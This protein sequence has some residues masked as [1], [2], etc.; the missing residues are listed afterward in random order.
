MDQV[1]KG[2]IPRHKKVLAELKREFSRVRPGTN[3]AKLR[4][5]P[6]LEHATFL[7]R[8]LRSPKFSRE[9]SRL[10]KGVAMFHSDLVYLRANIKALK[11]ILAAEKRGPSS[12]KKTKRPNQA[13]ARS[14]TLG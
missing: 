7:E 9:S 3:W 1:Y 13:P 4:I 14:A 2:D 5:Q 8:L 10:R 11:E 6:L 12:R